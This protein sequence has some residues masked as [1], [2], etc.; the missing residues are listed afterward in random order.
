M[1]VDSEIKK[2]YLDAVDSSQQSSNTNN[3]YEMS[4]RQEYETLLD[5]EIEL[6]N[7]KSAALKYTNNQMAAQGFASQGYGSSY[8]SGIAGRYLDALGKAQS[9]YKSNVDNINYQQ[10][11]EDINNAND[12]FKS[13]TTMLTQANSID[14]M[15]KLLSDYGYGS[16]VENDGIA[17]FQWNEKPDGIS[18]DDWYQMRYYYNLQKS[19]IESSDKVDQYAA[20]YGNRESWGSATYVNNKGS[21]NKIEDQ[22]KYE[23]NVLWANINAG[24]YTYGTT[25]RM[26]NGKGDVIYVQWT[27]NGLRMTDEATYNSSEN[28]DSLT[29]QKNVN[30]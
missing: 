6:E 1:A 20:T 2:K 15:D 8:H 13:I 9:N 30:K 3:Y 28:K 25:V 27:Q 10:H 17:E 11:Q 23:S 21:T 5:K 22:F 29:W 7:A 14:Q 26:Q 24:K 12:R 18:D 19:S 4:K 16:M